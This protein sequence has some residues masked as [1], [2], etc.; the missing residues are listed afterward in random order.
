MTYQVQAHV[1]AI[2]HASEYVAERFDSGLRDLRDAGF[3]VDWRHKS[4][5][6]DG[7]ECVLERLARFERVAL[8]RFGIVRVLYPFHKR[9]VVRHVPFDG[10]THRRFVNLRGVCLQRG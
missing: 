10:L 1:D 7:L 8:F 9:P 3:E 4:A 6:L 2:L 5:E